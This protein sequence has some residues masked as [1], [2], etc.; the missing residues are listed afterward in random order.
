VRLVR[1]LLAALD[2]VTV[3]GALEGIAPGSAR[4]L[5]LVAIAVVGLV[6]MF[7]AVVVL[8]GL[9]AQRQPPYPMGS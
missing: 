1:V 9:L 2:L 6:L 7:V 4:G 8:A 3:A 5:V